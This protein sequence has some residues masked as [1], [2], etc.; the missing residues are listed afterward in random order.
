MK[1][2]KS[3]REEE[4]VEAERAGIEPWVNKKEQGMLSSK[5]PVRQ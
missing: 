5:V 4:E 1:E 3:E 2:Q